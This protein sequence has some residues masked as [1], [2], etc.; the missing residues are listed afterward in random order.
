METLK[1]VLVVLQRRDFFLIRPQIM[2]SCG[3]EVI[4]EAAKNIPTEF[5]KKHNAI[6]WK[7][8]AGLR[9]KIIHEY[10]GIDLGNVW[11]VVTEDIPKLKKDIVEILKKSK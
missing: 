2:L 9:D 6:P 8:I 7:Q 4:G 10:F 5:R 1:I 3:I 11:K